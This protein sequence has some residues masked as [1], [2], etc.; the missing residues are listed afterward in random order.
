MRT[1][2]VT[3]ASMVR[4]R[5]RVVGWGMCMASVLLLR[6]SVGTRWDVLEV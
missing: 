2:A 1:L 5:R 3:E 6:S 4:S